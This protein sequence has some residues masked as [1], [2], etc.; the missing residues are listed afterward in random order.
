MKLKSDALKWKVN[1]QF[2]IYGYDTSSKRKKNLALKK[3]D[4]VYH[5]G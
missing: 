4:G 5:E 1:F 3:Y 2:Q